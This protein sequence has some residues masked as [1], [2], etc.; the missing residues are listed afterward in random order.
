M[1]TQNL[2]TVTIVTGNATK[3]AEMQH[4]LAPFG[5]HAVQNT[6]D[7][8]EIQTTDQKEAITQKV[9]DAHNALEGES[10]LVDDSGFF[11]EQYNAFPGVLSKYIFQMLGYRG[12]F[13]LYNEGDEAYFQCSVGYM[14]NTLEEPIIFTAQWHGLLTNEFH[15]EE[16][17]KTVAE[18]P[19]VAV[20]VPNDQPNKTIQKR[21][22]EFTPEE[23]V[24]DHRHQALAQFATWLLSR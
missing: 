12:L 5:I 23:R 18:M 13:R 24:G 8:H 21:L 17:E 4:A 1:S 20:F 6:I 2:K 9:L 7:L 10:V 3:F 14:D 15:I 16:A 22:A 11:I 19:Y